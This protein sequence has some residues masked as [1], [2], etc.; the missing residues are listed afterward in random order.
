MEHVTQT[1]TNPDL[2]LAKRAARADG[3]LLR[4][5][6]NVAPP[7]VAKRFP[8]SRRDLPWNES[9]KRLREE[10]GAFTFDPPSPGAY[11]VATSLRI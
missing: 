8:S 1:V 2:L 6:R 10:S 7:V 11:R 4:D 5:H 3:R 9:G